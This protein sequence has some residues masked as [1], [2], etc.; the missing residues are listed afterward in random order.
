VDELFSIASVLLVILVVVTL[1]G[2]GIWVL[3]AKLFG[4]GKGRAITDR[5]PSCGAWLPGRT[6]G[7]PTCGWGASRSPEHRRQDALKSLYQQIIALGRRGLLDEATKKRLSE[8]VITAQA[9]QIE[10]PPVASG[11]VPAGEVAGLP[12]PTIA[13]EAVPVAHAAPAPPQLAESRDEIGQPST[14][15]EVQDRVRRYM[16][17]QQTAAHDEAAH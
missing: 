4:A 3:L 6:G 11:E 2:H 17:R 13:A 9:P 5:C 8:S 14:P 1:V 12:K 10:R 15:V 7:C 16:E